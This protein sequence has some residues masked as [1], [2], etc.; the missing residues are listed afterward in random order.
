MQICKNKNDIG[1][2]IFKDKILKLWWKLFLN[3]RLIFS[4]K[5]LHP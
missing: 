5:N 2:V 3:N 1:E 4:G